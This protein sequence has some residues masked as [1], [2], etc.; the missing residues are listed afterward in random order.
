MSA[1]QSP[2]AWRRTPLRL[3]LI[4]TLAVAGVKLLA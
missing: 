3:M 4:A 2:A 1:R